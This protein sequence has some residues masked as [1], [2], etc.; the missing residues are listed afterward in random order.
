M[1]PRRGFLAIFA[2]PAHHAD[3][4]RVGSGFTHDS[5]HMRV[6]AREETEDGG[7]KITAVEIDGAE[8][9]PGG[10]TIFTSRTRKAGE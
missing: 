5:K 10:P 3:K 9:R 6:T 8:T 4:F 2:I 7:A 1:T